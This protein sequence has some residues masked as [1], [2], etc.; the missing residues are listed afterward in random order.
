MCIRSLPIKAKSKT[1]GVIQL[2]NKSEGV[3][4]EDDEEMMDT[5]LAL[6]G[7]ILL[8]SSLVAS[9]QTGTGNE[10]SGMSK[11]TGSKAPTLG[12]FVDEGDEEEDEED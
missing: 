11:A 8:E 5:F 10:L 1:V 7:P 6:V 9:T 4:D 2:I 12:G 3:F